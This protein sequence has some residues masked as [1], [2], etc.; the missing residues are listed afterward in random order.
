MGYLADLKAVAA[1]AGKQAAESAY[2]AAVNSAESSLGIEA[3]Q[4]EESKAAQESKPT[5][6]AAVGASPRAPATPATGVKPI[7]WL[8]WG[9][10]AL[11]L[12]AGYMAFAKPR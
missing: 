1:S 4:S 11:A 12:G 8:L 9:G 7:N 10:I 5:A 6:V 2:G 3:P